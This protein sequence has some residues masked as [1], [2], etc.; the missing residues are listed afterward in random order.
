MSPSLTQLWLLL[1]LF[2]SIVTANTEKT[3]FVAPDAAPVRFS[4]KVNTIGELS[5]KPES[6]KLL[7]R[8]KLPRAFPT[9][10]APRGIDS[11][12][13]LGNLKP[14]ARYEARI[15]WAATTPSD[16]WL[17]THPHLEGPKFES[18]SDSKSSDESL[19]PAQPHLYLKIS[20]IASYYTTNTTL[21]ENPE[22]VLVDVI[23][24]EFLQGALPRS[25]VYVTVFIIV[26]INFS[27]HLGI[28]V[29]KWIEGF[30]NPNQENNREKTE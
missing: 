21:M 13:F 16:F 23:L 15:C 4:N 11:W 1:L 12:V 28:F 26:M 6:E 19:L 27:W 8:I 7:L 3:I 18:T 24:D 25:L 9:A 2:V 29:V 17:E 20:A 5:D 30:T 22:P 14:G 10:N